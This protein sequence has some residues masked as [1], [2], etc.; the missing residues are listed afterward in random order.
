M[1]GLCAGMREGGEMK[2]GCSTSECKKELGRNFETLPFMQRGDRGVNKQ[3]NNLPVS[4]CNC[5]ELQ[6]MK[7]TEAAGGGVPSLHE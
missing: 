3:T 1:C 4:T 6:N 2:M 5:D 7:G